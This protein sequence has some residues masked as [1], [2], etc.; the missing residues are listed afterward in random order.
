MNSVAACANKQVGKELR[1][2][3]TRRRQRT[4]PGSTGPGFEYSAGVA[5]MSTLASRAGAPGDGVLR[6]R[7]TEYSDAFVTNLRP[8]IRARREERRLH[9]HFTTARAKRA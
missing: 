9:A 6:H 3:H 1:G 7:R 4:F 5:G 2:L 8:L